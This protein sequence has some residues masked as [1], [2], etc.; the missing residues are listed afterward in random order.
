MKLKENIFLLIFILFIAYYLFPLL[1]FTENLAVGSG[2]TYFFLPVEQWFC[3]HFF[4]YE[5]FTNRFF[6]PT[7]VDMSTTYDMPLL[8]TLGCPL[9]SLGPFAPINF[10]AIIQVCLIFATSYF[11]AKKHI[12]HPL[13]RWMFVFLY[14]FS[15]FYLNR[16]SV[17]ITILSCIWTTSLVWLSLYK[18][19]LTNRKQVLLACSAIALCFLTSWQNLPNLTPLILILGIFSLK[20]VQKQKV[21]PVILNLTFGATIFL[22]IIAPFLFPL[23]RKYLTGEFSSA[24]STSYDFNL[25]LFSLFL[26]P[27]KS[28]LFDFFKEHFSLIM[29]KMYYEKTAG[30]SWMTYILLIFFAKMTST[31]KFYLD[32][33]LMI[34]GFSYLVI[35][36]G[37]SLNIG[38]HV[39]FDLPYFNVLSKIPPFTASRAPARMAVPF[40]FCFTLLS[41]I[42]LERWLNKKSPRYKWLTIPVFVLILYE[43]IILPKNTQMAHEAFPNERPAPSALDITK[44]IKETAR[45]EAIFLPLPIMLKQD[46]ATN[47]FQAFHNLPVIHAYLSYTVIN[48]K[49]FKFIHDDPVLSKLDCYSTPN[50]AQLASN[51]FALNNETLLVDSLKKLNI[52][53]ISINFSFFSS[54]DCVNFIKWYNNYFLK[55]KSFEYL[56]EGNA[57]KFY[58][59]AQ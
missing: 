41:I 46:P 15:P 5:M 35:S 23:I 50:E 12:E 20:Q 6:A 38:D 57:H 33:L 45:P 29:P 59:V 18:I 51:Q 34:I 32:R 58:K 8:L 24:A 9:Q 4:K 55:M 40:I 53:Y 49:L 25:D 44:N 52:D 7:G 16:E 56:G 1:N 28:P 19:D 13:L 11:V 14:S 27:V 26:P 54:P 21:K 48:D 22:F 10:I 2:D 31:K 3:S 36:F 17:H 37:P 39:L 30:L 47:F 43:T 42:C